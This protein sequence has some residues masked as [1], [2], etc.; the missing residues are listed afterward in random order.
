M[1]QGVEG[2]GEEVRVM[3]LLPQKVKMGEW[4][5]FGEL[6]KEQELLVPP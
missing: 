4:Q 2:A 6:R 1:L 3:M 5:W